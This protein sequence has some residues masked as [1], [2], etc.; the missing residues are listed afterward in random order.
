MEN[1]NHFQDYIF[2]LSKRLWLIIACFVVIFSLAIFYNLSQTPIYQAISTIEIHENKKQIVL[3]NQQAYAYKDYADKQRAFETHFKR[4]KSYPIIGQIVDRLQLE[5]YYQKQK[6]K[7]KKPQGIQAMLLDLNRFVQSFKSRIFVRKEKK[8]EIDTSVQIDTYNPY[9]SL[10][11]ASI[12]IAPVTDT[13]FTNLICKHFDP[14]MASRIVNTL[15]EVYK[16]YIDNKQL[17]M[18]RES[19]K[20]ISQEIKRLKNKLDQSEKEFHKFKRK[21][22]ILSMDI[23]KDIEAQELSQIRSK[24][25]NTQIQKNEL[26]AQV[27]EL[28]N[29]IA[30]NQRHVPAFLEGEGIRNIRNSLTKNQMELKKLY[31]TY[32]HKHPKIIKTKAN[33]ANLEK[34]FIMELVKITS[35]IKSQIRVMSSKENNLL[36]TLKK[37]REQMIQSSPKNVQFDRLYKE[38]KTNIELYNYLMRQLKSLD[39]KENVREQG[40]TIVEKAKLPQFPISPKTNMNLIMGAMTGLLL[41]ISLAFFSEYMDQSIKGIEDVEKLLE[42]P[43]LGVIPRFNKN[44][45]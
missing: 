28:D 5:K 10:V 19:F 40:I 29:I 42:L 13:N 24:L 17:D 23:D 31:K 34:H 1:N 20:W 12:T 33:I 18:N 14:V 37:R 6:K 30:Q 45:I 43:V 2:L 39:I 44:N 8:E 11:Q 38:N 35:G 25:S 27:E 22:K 9:I 3:P 16:N 7:E 21:S 36:D 32:K 15:A 41:G 26:Q 4:L